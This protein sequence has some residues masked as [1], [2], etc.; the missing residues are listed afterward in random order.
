LA[1]VRMRGQLAKQFARANP[2][3]F[4]RLTALRFYMFWCGVPHATGDAWK[5]QAAEFVR[6]SAY[7]FGSITGLLGAWLALRRRLPAAGIFA[8]A[9]LLLP[10]VY[11]FVT[12]GSRFRN[13][14][15]P[16]LV[17]LTVYLFQQAELRWG[18]SVF[19]LD[20]RER[21]ANM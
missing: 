16:I 5:A 9:I 8:W 18:F 21:N 20:R 11:Y 2:E 19:G 1:Y 12:A 7:C 3:H 17:V 4:W 15:E 6:G 13:P 14:L 10:V